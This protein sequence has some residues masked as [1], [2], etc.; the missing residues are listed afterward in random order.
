MPFFQ[1]VLLEDKITS[2]IMFLGFEF[3]VFVRILVF[4][5]IFIPNLV[6]LQFQKEVAE[7]SPA[8]TDVVAFWMESNLCGVCG[9]NK[10]MH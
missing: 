8:I 1:R 10:Q 5:V 6:L 2:C 3:S 9:L 4:C 7:I